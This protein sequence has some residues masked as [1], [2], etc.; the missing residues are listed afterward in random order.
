LILRFADHLLLHAE[1]P[2]LGSK[3]WTF[4][5]TAS[6][7]EIYNEKIYDLLGG[8]ARASQ[9]LDIKLEAH[10]AC[11][12]SPR[13]TD[14]H[15]ADCPHRRHLRN[16]HACGLVSFDSSSQEPADNCGAVSGLSVVCA[17]AAKRTHVPGLEEVGVE[18]G[19]QIYQL[20]K[21]AAD[22][23]STS[24]T[25]MNERSSRSHSVF[26]LK[27]CG[28]NAETSEEANGVLNLIDLVSGLAPTATSQLTALATPPSLE[29]HIYQ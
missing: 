13:I 16:A 26:Q 7:L 5:V 29:D 22:S 21:R 18:S 11:C 4:T 19:V 2:A 15:T 23:R 25:Q 12:C 27:I 20:L 9:A 14:R 8:G 24:A 28:R 10:S 3:G 17:Y 1:I 6:F